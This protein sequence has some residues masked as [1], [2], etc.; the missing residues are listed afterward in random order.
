MVDHYVTDVAPYRCTPTEHRRDDNRQL[1]LSVSPTLHARLGR[2]AAERGMPLEDWAVLKLGLNRLAC[3]SLAHV[4][5]V[6]P[7][8]TRC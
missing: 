3:S 8:R 7:W 1:R 4:E 6:P 2:E 5:P